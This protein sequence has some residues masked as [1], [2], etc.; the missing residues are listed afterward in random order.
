MI[1]LHNIA[2]SY[3]GKDIILPLTETIT[4]KRT[5]IVGPNGSGKT[6]ILSIISGALEPD[7]GEV[8]IPKGK[9]VHT[10][11]QHAAYSLPSMSVI[12]YLEQFEK[13]EQLSLLL[14]EEAEILDEIEKDSES[15]ALHKLH[16]IH[17]KI[18]A[19]EISSISYVSKQDIIEK[20]SFSEEILAAQ[21]DTL[22]GGWRIKLLLAAAMMRNPDILLL[23]EPTNY[24]DIESTAFLLKWIKQYKGFIVTVSH[25]H[26]FLDSVSDETWE[27]M[28]GI[29]TKY[30]GNYSFYLKDRISKRILL[31]KQREK[32]L[33][34]LKELSAF[35][36]RFRSKANTASRAQS[37][38]KEYDKLTN[39]LVEVPPL[40]TTVSFSFPKPIRGG[41]ISFTLENSF[42]SYEATKP[43][44]TDL[45]T[46][47]KRGQKIALVGKN[48][49]G[50]STL[51][52]ILSG[53]IKPVKGSI[54]SYKQGKIV[55]Y[56]QHEA[57]S[58]PPDLTVID[59][60]HTITPFD[61]IPSIR[62]ILASFLF[63][64][65][66]LDTK[67]AALSGGEKV[68]LALLK[69]LMIPSTVLL[70]DEPTTHLD[71]ESRKVLLRYLQNYSETVVFVSH[72]SHFIENIADTIF[73]FEKSGIVQFPGKLSEYTHQQEP[74]MVKS[75]KTAP[76]KK[77]KT[78]SQAEWE[79]SKKQKK[80]FNKLKKI[81]NNIEIEIEVCEKSIEKSEGELT[82]T[83]ANIRELSLELKNLQKNLDKLYLD[84]E[85]TSQKI[86]KLD[87]IF[88]Q[89]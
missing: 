2:K 75:F 25:D 27:I 61:K 12:S 74:Q 45:T 11:S 73:Y 33:I 40:S 70:F 23:D 30:S 16:E 19:E 43:I 4:K 14:K 82:K 53:I 9:S 80:L 49:V 22:S 10:I 79:E 38:V 83:G 46:V 56:R 8:I 52:N 58:L 37:A 39:A 47:I 15:P 41:D 69:L 6:T 66:S 85:N 13:S 35:I 18:E 87:G 62:S 67:I 21:T 34:R 55:T 60:M 31:E 24:L 88:S 86:E 54:S 17:E 44:I 36:E 84:W 57:E 5:T 77:E 28:N 20:L 64:E 48:G 63:L 26:E 29:I 1:H 3:A 65:E 81:I 7:F 78:T 32:Q 68:R 51:I 71:I 50:K 76:L 59:F 42:F 72:D 89:E